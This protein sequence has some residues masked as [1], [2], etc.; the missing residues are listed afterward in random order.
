M[1]EAFILVYRWSSS[2]A[3]VTVAVRIC[4]KVGCPSI[5]TKQVVVEFKD[6][7]LFPIRK[8]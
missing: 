3:K 1:Q 6:K 5:Y 4:S 8:A 2:R 7:A